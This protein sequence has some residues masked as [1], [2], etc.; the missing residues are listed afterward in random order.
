MNNKLAFGII[1]LM[2][3]VLL[4]TGCGGGGKIVNPELEKNRR[5]WREKKIAD[6]NFVVWKLDGQSTDWLPSQIQ[7]RNNQMISKKPLGALG[8]KTK[9]DDYRDFETIEE[10]FETIRQAYDKGQAVTV[11]YHGE[12]GYPEKTI[13]NTMSATDQAFSI[14]ISKFELA[15][16]N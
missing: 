11:T 16:S 2:G 10:T 4:A 6:Y 5:L 3:W 8:P 15:G 14:E 1:F 7:V 12:F 9:I 13:I